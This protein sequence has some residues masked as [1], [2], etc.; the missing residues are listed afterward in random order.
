V[1]A[2]ADTSAPAA[3]DTSA[4]AAAAAAASPVNRVAQLVVVL[5]V[6]AL[7]GPACQLCAA[8][9]A[10]A[11]AANDTKQHSK[12]HFSIKCGERSNAVTLSCG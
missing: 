12:P 2:A 11:S 4:A 8:A 3:A 6:Q 5:G 9:A 7:L 1:V 10:A